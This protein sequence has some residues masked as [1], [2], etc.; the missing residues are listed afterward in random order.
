MKGILQSK[1]NVVMKGSKQ[2]KKVGVM[3]KRSIIVYV[4]LLKKEETHSHTKDKKV[5]LGELSLVGSL[6]NQFS[7]ETKAL[8][9]N[10]LPRLEDVQAFNTE[11][12]DNTGRKQQ[13]P[14]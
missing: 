8:A 14:Q 12:F 5:H 9:S 11:G 10:L 1:K 4:C 13:E 7:I 6:K 3:L 2:K